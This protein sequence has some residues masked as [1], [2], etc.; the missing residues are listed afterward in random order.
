MGEKGR[1]RGPRRREFGDD[2]FEMRDT[3]ESPRQPLR[4]TSREDTVPTGRAVEI[5]SGRPA[6]TA[7][8]KS[9]AQAQVLAFLKTSATQAA[10]NFFAVMRSAAAVV[11]LIHPQ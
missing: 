11:L 2:T 6:G 8:G 1:E 7:H 4:R 9:P 3:R 5:G 10:I